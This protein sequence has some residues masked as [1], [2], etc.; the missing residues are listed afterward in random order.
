MHSGRL[1]FK[2]TKETAWLKVSARI[3]ESKVIPLK[4]STGTKFTRWAVAAAIALAL[5]IGGA[6][7]FGQ[8]L[9]V[10][11]TANVRAVELIDGS[12]VTL[13]PQAELAYNTFLW[14]W[15]R[16]VELQGEAFFEVVH[17]NDFAV[18][19]SL[20]EVHVLGTSFNVEASDHSFDV[21]CKT[22][23]VSVNSIHG[24][25][26]VLEPGSGFSVRNGNALVYQMP[27][28][29]MGVWVNGPYQFEG[30]SLR[31]VLHEIATDF[32]YQFDIRG[33]T[34][35]KFTGSFSRDEELV[36]MM[37]I[38]CKPLGLGFHID[39]DKRLISIL[40]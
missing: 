21:K 10:N 7:Y 29:R 1:P 32:N 31:R 30:A 5:Y 33:E 9:I 35:L 37:E 4:K 13:R 12:S 19:T 26:T 2:Q 8:R 27:I 23:K 25:G 24:D 16:T 39:E 20:G 6:T 40:K 11:A 38:V 36:D 22:G 17:G 14:K 3:D 28:A 18:Q 15:S 34:N